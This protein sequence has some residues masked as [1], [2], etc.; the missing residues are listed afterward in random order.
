[1]SIFDKEV[2]TLVKLIP[3]PQ[4]PL[5]RYVVAL[6]MVLLSLC[7]RLTIGVWGGIYGFVFFIPAIV[8]A[9]VL[10]GLDS[11]LVAVAASATAVALILDWSGPH[12]HLTALLTFILIGSGLSL[13]GDALRRVIGSLNRA[14]ADNEMLLEEMSHRV[15]NKFAVIVSIIRLQAK[16]AP[17]EAQPAL[18]A[19]ARR[20]H[21]LATLHTHLQGSRRSGLVN[22]QDYLR[23]LCAGLRDTAGH[24]RTIT[25]SVTAEPIVLPPREATAVGLIV[26]E[27]IM[28]CYKYAFPGE[29]PGSI[30]VTFTS[31]EGT[32]ILSVADDGA[33]LADGSVAGTGTELVSLLAEQLGGTVERA[34]AP[35][36]GC[37]VTV[38]APAM[39]ISDLPER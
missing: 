17:A 36:G 16:A 38:A 34:R 7:V 8:L 33:G 1:M 19:I 32:T 35:Q 15:K 27:L 37:V 13:L 2:D 24:L 22:M 20:V 11:G 14:R 30:K 21:A 6:G 25:H 23:D 9:A 3:E 12:H 10:L 26:N 4:P 29:R 5:V 31:T 18:D 28:N 39:A